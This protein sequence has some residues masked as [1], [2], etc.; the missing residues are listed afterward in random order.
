MDV[1]REWAEAVEARR[2]RVL[3]YRIRVMTL[4]LIVAGVWLVMLVDPGVGPMLWTAVGAFGLTVVGF[5]AMLGLVWVGFRIF[6]LG[7]WLVGVVRRLGSWEEQG[8][9]FP[10]H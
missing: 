3:G 5:V 10:D 8:N 4:G 2:Q 9:G 7:D 1:D 6:D